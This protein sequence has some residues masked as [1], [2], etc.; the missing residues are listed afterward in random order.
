[1][2]FF[3]KMMKVMLSLVTEWSGSDD[4]SSLFT[5]C[6]TCIKVTGHWG[7]E[8][9]YLMTRHA[10]APDTQHY[11]VTVCLCIRITQ[12]LYYDYIAS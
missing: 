1:M 12:Y 10:G 5:E 3:Y 7:C 9:G 8:N 2:L 11:L 6:M 4:D